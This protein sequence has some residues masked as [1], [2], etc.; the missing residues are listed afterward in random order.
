MLKQTE[1]KG[2]ERLA[3]ITSVIALAGPIILVF[4]FGVTPGISFIE[5]L[6]RHL[7]MGRIIL[8]THTVPDTNLLTYTCPDF[9]F[10]NH[11]WLFQCMVANLYSKVGLN[12]LILLKA[13][14][15][16][17]SLTFSLFSAFKTQVLKD[18]FWHSNLVVWVSG[19]LAAIIMG[20]R[21]HIRPELFS[22]LFVGLMLLLFEITRRRAQVK[23]GFGYYLSRILPLL[24]LLLWANIHI[25]FIFGLGM[26]GAFCLERW[27][28]KPSW[29]KL[30]REAAWFLAAVG[31]CFCNPSGWAGLIY[32][33]TILSNYGVA[34]TENRSPFELWQTAVNPMLLALPL[35][36]LMTL[37]AL[38][39]V[40]LTAI[41]QYRSEKQILWN[42]IRPASGIIALAALIAAMMMVRHTPLL[43]LSAIP[44]IGLAS[45]LRIKGQK[46]RSGIQS[47]SYAA[48]GGTL[49]LN[50]FLI[51]TL[52]EGSYSRRFSAPIAPT[53]FGL[54]DQTRYERLGQLVRQYKI[55]GP[56]FS[57]FNIGSLV[58]YNLYPTPGYVDNRPEAF[59][60]TFWN[61][62]YY[63]AMNSPQQ[64]QNLMEK[65]G[66]NLI[67]L[68]LWHQV[69]PISFNPE[70]NPQ[71]ALVYMDEY[72]AVWLKKSASNREALRDLEFSKIRMERYV[73]KIS[74][75][76][77]L[78]PDVSIWRRQILAE[79]VLF[80]LYGVIRAGYA[81][82]ARPYL[83]Q[84]LV[85]YPDYEMAHEVL[86]S[87][88]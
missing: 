19:I 48:A 83:K 24:V 58:E 32:P 49:I 47:L 10:I 62:E 21:S 2:M 56:V 11:H 4:L 45:G 7:L 3:R 79:S 31:A 28:L 43:A 5:D 30:G 20:Y 26:A 40:C 75:D 85:L 66:I 78:I 59:P 22:F 80:R 88:S 81:G 36:V 1:M 76:L 51:A 68:S 82:L 84:L 69:L 17:A 55:D 50:I 33:F 8:D 44:M 15:L 54:D 65:R 64:F 27:L 73:R 39:R 67:A 6:G 29:R 74:E 72:M 70:E 12:G 52:L 61:D 13:I 35:I 38:G 34:I 16:A 86:R 42:E 77:L 41:R 57:D 63:P 9:P 23:I 71:W 60:M 14:L 37:L 87:I 53:P 18:A 25:Y 46:Q